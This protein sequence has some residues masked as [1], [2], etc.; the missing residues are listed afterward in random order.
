MPTVQ[1]AHKNTF[2]LR[3]PTLITQA[4]LTAC[5]MKVY[6]PLFPLCHGPQNAEGALSAVEK[7]V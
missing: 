5:A 7:V 2:T 1:A 6:F 3:Y 4:A